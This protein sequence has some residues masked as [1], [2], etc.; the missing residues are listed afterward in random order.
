MALT[1]IVYENPTGSIIGKYSHDG[2]TFSSP[3]SIATGSSPKL[4]YETDGTI[5]LTYHRNGAFFFVELDGSA[6]L[7]TVTP[8]TVFREYIT[9]GVGISKRHGNITAP[10][11]HSIP[12]INDE[13]YVMIDVPNDIEG[14]VINR[15]L[16]SGFKSSIIKTGGTFLEKLDANYDTEGIYYQFY[17]IYPTGTVSKSSARYYVKPESQ[18]NFWEQHNPYSMEHTVKVDMVTTPKEQKARQLC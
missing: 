8:D 12:T 4:S 14:M 2:V 11:F 13:C 17:F 3:V 1:W 18:K 10:F 7:P 16:P 5:K 6:V 15:M 9:S